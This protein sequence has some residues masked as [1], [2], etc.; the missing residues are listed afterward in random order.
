MTPMIIFENEGYEGH[1]EFGAEIDEN[2]GLDICVYQ[3]Q[4]YELWTSISKDK[5]PALIEHLTNVYNESNQ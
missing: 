4:D 2:G 5:I 1:V 3:S